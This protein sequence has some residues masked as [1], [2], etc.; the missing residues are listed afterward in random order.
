MLGLLQYPPVQRG[1]MALLLG[2]VLFPQAGL[3][4]IR[5]N[6][7]PLRFM[8]IHGLLLGGALGLA[9]GVSPLAGSLVINTLLISLLL[10]LTRKLK[11]N[12]GYFS[13]LFMVLS[14]SLAAFVIYRFKVPARDTLFIL[15]GSP[16]TVTVTELWLLLLLTLVALSL[17]IIFHR[18]IGAL[19][20][21]PELAQTA[22][23]NEKLYTWIMVWFI[24]LV[25]SFAMKLLGAMLLDLLLL[26]P[27]LAVNWT[28][29]SFKTAS[30]A[31]SL[32]GG[33]M[34]LTGF[35]LALILDIPVSTALAI[36]VV[37]MVIYIVIRRNISNKRS[38]L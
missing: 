38:T 9:T 23:I 34:A 2:G 8:L 17:R 1:L 12:Y 21:D 20:F 33:G 28:A 18:Q 31:A 16:F 6:L 37:L 32:I 29:R 14:A 15:W 10:Y 13:A 36:P 35:F 30:W 19:F 7:V 11:G 22:G 4:V 27:A 25:V 3:A 24:A 5:L 26:L